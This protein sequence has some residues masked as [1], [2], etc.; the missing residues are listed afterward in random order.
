MALALLL[1]TASAGAG[2]MS[3]APLLRRATIRGVL[4]GCT[5]DVEFSGLGPARP[6]G[7]TSLWHGADGGPE[8]SVS[9]GETFTSD[10]GW[11]GDVCGRTVVVNG[12]QGQAQMF[13]GVE[14]SLTGF[15]GGDQGGCESSQCAE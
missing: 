8:V 13:R 15:G 2:T 3:V 4:G 9:G 7:N 1:E 10:A 6:A 5:L 12:G 14:A 11:W